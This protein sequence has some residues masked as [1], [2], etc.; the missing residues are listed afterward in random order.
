MAKFTDEQYATINESNAGRFDPRVF[1]NCSSVNFTI[2]NVTMSLYSIN[3]TMHHMSLAN[4]GMHYTH[5]LSCYMN[6]QLRRGEN[7]KWEE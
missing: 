1:V 6:C 2:I 5:P 3:H 4:E 7:T